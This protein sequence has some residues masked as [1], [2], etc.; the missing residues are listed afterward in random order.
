VRLSDSVPDR[1]RCRHH[2]GVLIEHR[3]IAR[4]DLVL[5]QAFQDWAGRF[6]QNLVAL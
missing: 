3:E 6:E 5:S 1:G 4:P 2:H